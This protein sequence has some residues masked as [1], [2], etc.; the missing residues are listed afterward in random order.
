M[1]EYLARLLNLANNGLSDVPYR[2]SW[3]RSTTCEHIDTS[4]S[5]SGRRAPRTS[6]ETDLPE[7]ARAH[8]TLR[9]SDGGARVNPF[10]YFFRRHEN[11]SAWA[12]DASVCFLA[13]DAYSL[14]F[15]YALDF[16]H[17]LVSLWWDKHDNKLKYLEQKNIIFTLFVPMCLLTK[18]KI[19][20]KRFCTGTQA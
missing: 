3:S 14:N 20:F 1:C 2:R 18:R 19:L 17:C 9:N 10:E 13:L 15:S 11:G 12:T 7:S 6:D 8:Q 4:T 16:N 5:A